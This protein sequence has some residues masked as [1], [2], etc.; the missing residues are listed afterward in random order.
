MVEVDKFQEGF[1]TGALL[2]LLL[3]HGLLHLQWRP[4]DARYNGMSVF[5][6]VGAIVEGLNNDSLL[7][8]HAAVQN[9]DN[10]PLLKAEKTF[11]SIYQ[12]IPQFPPHS[13][14][15]TTTL[16]RNTKEFGCKQ[17]EAEGVILFTATFYIRKASSSW[18]T[19]RKQE[20][21]TFHRSV[22]EA[23]IT[24]IYDTLTSLLTPGVLE[25]LSLLQQL[26]RPH[27]THTHRERC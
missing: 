21:K 3:G 13:L 22:A 12:M 19:S 8:S 14:T 15:V 17:R 9:N 11:V 1:D 7:S 18:P 5:S 16:C 6:A 27:N 26:S 20:A 2:D 23:N 24:P 10:L 25:H 4:V